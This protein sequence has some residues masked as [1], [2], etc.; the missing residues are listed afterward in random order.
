MFFHNNRELIIAAKDV[1]GIA[2]GAN[3]ARNNLDKI[4]D[5]TEQQ[6]ADLI[7]I[8]QLTK[9]TEEALQKLNATGD[10]YIRVRLG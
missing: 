9:E 2:K 8:T 1:E 3:D 6:K 7:T 4:E 5:K 10:E